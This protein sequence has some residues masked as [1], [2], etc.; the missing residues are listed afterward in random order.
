MKF[1]TNNNEEEEGELFDF[2]SGD[3]VPEADRQ[4]PSAHGMSGGAEGGDA[5]ETV[6]PAGQPH[7]HDAVGP[8]GS[9]LTPPCLQDSGGLRPCNQVAEVGLD[10]HS[11]RA[12]APSIEIQSRAA[13]MMTLRKTERRKLRSQDSSFK[14]T[15][16]QPQ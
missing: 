1:D 16:A 2:D 3:E 15:H 8:A 5:G 11:Q 9:F 10:S 7:S 14:D 12:W 6:S 13:H 4:A